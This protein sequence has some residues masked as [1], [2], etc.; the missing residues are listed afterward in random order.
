M[1][2]VILFYFSGTGNTEKVSIILSDTLK[3]QGS[4]VTL[5]NIEDFL[6]DNISI[7]FDDYD[8]IG[9]AYPIYGFGTPNIIFELTDK[10][11]TS[12]SKDLF[13][14]K[15]GGDYISIN[16][17]ASKKLIKK[18]DIK[19]YNVFYDRIIVMPSNWVV[20]YSDSLIKQLYNV[21]PDKVKH[22]AHD[23][24]T[25]TIRIYKPNIFLQLLSKGIFHL[26]ETY[27]ARFF[28]KSLIVKDTCI[29]CGKCIKECP[30]NNIKLN[31]SKF[32]F[33]GNCI[34][35][36][37][38]IYNCPQ[39]AITSK[40]M[41]FCILKGGYNIDGIINNPE[42]KADYLTEK[43]KGFFR[44]LYTYIIDDTL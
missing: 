17:T 39:N 9:I 35:C 3:S 28:G 1:K 30:K 37:R 36:M 42:I 41:K 10:F 7:S 21:V 8:L 44:H 27:G 20:G 14:L 32:K 15:T 19:G 18:L 4:V 2:S 38:C 31:N 25:L 34:M 24:L 16:H 5:V 12:K 33:S 29:N 26:E 43:T 6:E 11:P 40:S 13:L 22:M 23:I